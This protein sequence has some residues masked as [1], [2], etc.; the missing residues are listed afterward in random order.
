MVISVLNKAVKGAFRM[1]KKTFTFQSSNEKN[2]IAGVMWLPDYAPRAVL[3]IS[4]GM[5]EHIDRYED[6]ARFMVEHGILIVGNDHIGHGDSVETKDG[7]G[8]FGGKDGG[9]YIVE[10]LCH[11]TR[12]VR[13]QYPDI[14]YFLLGHSMGSFMAR[15]YIMNY[16]N[17]I[18]GVIIMGTGD[19]PIIKVLCGK[20]M[21]GLVKAIK[22]DHYRSKLIDRLMF[23]SY[24][25]RIADAKRGHDWLTTD[26]KVVEAYEQEESCMFLF[27]VNGIQSLMDTILYIKKQNNIRKIPKNLPM[28]VIAG[29]DDPVGGYGQDVEKFYNV[30]CSIGMKN[31][32]CKLYDGM[33]HEILNER[34]KL[35]VYDDLLEWIERKIL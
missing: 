33:R 5:I 34:E 21:A 8:Y 12:F 6:F 15:R 11:L 28:L 24:N 9:K 32:K 18:D 27:T 16:G 31:V 14:P 10:D 19:Q 20:Y 26:E 2:T 22:G 30:M 29:K 23:E 1:V 3:Q 4:H 13:N 17:Q 7:W 35:K 25:K